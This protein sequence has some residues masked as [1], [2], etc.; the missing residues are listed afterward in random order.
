MGI[1][2]FDLAINCM[3][4]REIIDAFSGG[5]V[6]GD[7]VDFIGV[8]SNIGVNTLI[9]PTVQDETVIGASQLASFE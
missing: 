5:G 9:H 3:W 4:R 1:V 6:Y 8:E 7:V 2:V